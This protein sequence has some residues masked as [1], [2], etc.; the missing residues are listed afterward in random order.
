MKFW[1]VF[2]A[3]FICLLPIS[4]L[5]GKSAPFKG[6]YPIISATEKTLDAPFF[7]FDNDTLGVIWGKYA[8]GPLPADLEKYREEQ[9]IL[10]GFS[11]RS[12]LFLALERGALVTPNYLA[13]EGGEGEK[14]EMRRRPDGKM[15]MATKEAG[16]TTIYLLDAPGPVPDSN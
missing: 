11:N 6:V 7:L 8:D 4:A 10:A 2:L 3:A 5:A 12:L 16:R 14:L 13:V 15:D 9:T 1:K